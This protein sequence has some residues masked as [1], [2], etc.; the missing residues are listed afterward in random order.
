MLK[1]YAMSV[2]G[3]DRHLAARMLLR[4]KYEELFSQEMPEIL[5]AEDGKPYFADASCYFSI[6]YTGDFCFVAISDTPVGLDCEKIRSVS[7]EAVVRILSPA[8]WRQ[9]SSAKDPAEMFMRFWTLKE[10]YCKFTSLGIVKSKIRHT[11]FDLTRLSPYLSGHE[12]LRFWCRRLDSGLS[13]IV[14]SLCSNSM[15]RPEFYIVE[16]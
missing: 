12:E 5:E 6:S 4:W 15:H 16:I 2:A 8:E 13:D 1:V 7:S 10:A 3:E 9:Y 14:L 11:E